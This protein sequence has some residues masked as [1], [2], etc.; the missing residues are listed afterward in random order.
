MATRSYFPSKDALL[1]AW[2]NN[3]AS[4]LTAEFAA[5]GCTAP[6]AAAFQ[7][8]ADDLASSYATA[9]E[10]ST[11][12]KGTVAAKNAAKEAMKISARNLALII[13]AQNLSDEQIIDIG[14]TVKDGSAT[15]INPPEAAPM[16]E[17]ISIMGRLVRGRVHSA[18]SETRGKPAGVAA[19]W[20]Y[21][22]IGAAPPADIAAWKFEGSATRTSWE[23][24][25]PASVAAGSQFWLC[26]QWISP[27]NQP[28]PACSPITNFMGGGV[29]TE[30]G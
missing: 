9:I 13:Y 19:A 15:P 14:L 3:F 4:I 23:I 22:Y 29:E 28:G 25:F 20:L 10:P 12:T 16:A 1:V 18:D 5:Y 11:R 30:V 27:R 26:A 17:I 2:A 7:A 8:L 6:Q 21:S 24:E